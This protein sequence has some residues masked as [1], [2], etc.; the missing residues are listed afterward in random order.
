MR[1]DVVVGSFSSAG[2]VRDDNQDAFGY[3]EPDTH[4]ELAAK[5]RLVVVADG[6]GGEAAGDV[7]S[8]LAVESVRN[9]Y[10]GDVSDDPSQAL[11]RSLEAANR[12]IYERAS[13]EP[14][15]AGMGTTCTALVI[16][17]EE[18]HL[19]HV[20]DT[21]AYLIRQGSITRLT[22]DHSLASSGRANVLTRALGV[23]AASLDVDV[24]HPPV[25]TQR[26]DAWLLCSD[27]LWGQVT[28][29][30]LL[31]ATLSS[32]DV[33]DVCRRLVACA[34]GR[35]GPDNI[36]VQLVRI[37]AGAQGDGAASQAPVRMWRRLRRLL[38]VP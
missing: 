24:L 12:A 11:R 9:S 18:A 17:S 32:R 13:A 3:F 6:M 19:A 8:R 34:N 30:E 20:G 7:A 1:A 15:L 35:G 37:E 33:Q 10:F 14:G 29:D 38:G 5:G 28:D 26:G 21:R 22:R 23:A 2:Q 27:G 31:E 36:T 25:A 4:E 16:R